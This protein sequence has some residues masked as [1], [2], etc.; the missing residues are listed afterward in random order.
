MDFQGDCD[1][2]F[3]EKGNDEEFQPCRPLAPYLA[4][5]YQA[6]TAPRC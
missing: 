2:R 6:L 4:Y 1:Y 3:G 5:E